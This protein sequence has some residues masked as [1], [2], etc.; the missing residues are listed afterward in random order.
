M[1]K[2]SLFIG[3]STEGVEFARAVRGR[4][5]PDVE[6]SLWDEGFFNLGSTFI[7]TLVNS[8]SRF[9][10]AVLILTPDD[11]VSS[12]DNESFG[13]RDNVIFELG[14]FMG[15]LGRSR[16]FV[17][18]ADD[19]RLKIPTDLSGVNTAKYYWPRAD[20]NHS[21]AVGTASD[22]IRKVI[23]ELGVSESK[24]SRQIQEVRQ[25]QDRLQGEVDALRFLVAGFVNDYE[26]IHLSKLADDGI[27]AYERSPSRDDNRFVLQLTRLKDVGLIE[28][29]GV[30][31]LW[32]IPLSGNLKDYV[33]ITQRG[34]DYLKLRRQVSP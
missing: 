16:T 32:D 17:V 14:L 19:P 31:S 24:T 4:L 3:S 15:R 26:I 2:P 18:H 22:N 12:R 34:R 29:C 23:R 8:L 30:T 20:N 28:K 33:K 10:F 25:N 13:P 1:A 11:L 21:A 7:E 6:V 9:D 27:F 5:E